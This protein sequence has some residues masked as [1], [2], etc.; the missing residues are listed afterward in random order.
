MSQ[1]QELEQY[2]D[3]LLSAALAQCGNL[4]DAEDLA[5]D[6]VLAVLTYL[7]RGGTIENMRAFLTTVIRRTFYGRLREKYRFPTVSLDDHPEVYEIAEEES[8]DEDYQRMM[9]E[10]V[11]LTESYREVL[12]RHYFRGQGL[13]KIADAL[14]IP[15]GTVKSRL[16]MGREKIRKGMDTNMEEYQEQSYAP[17]RLY[18]WNSGNPGFNGEP[19][20][21][22]NDDLIA[23]NLLILAYPAPIT[24]SDLAKA[25][26]IATA[27]V[28]PIVNKL[29]DNELMKRVSNRVYTDFLINDPAKIPDTHDKQLAFVKKNLELIFTP[30]TA[31]LNAIKETD[32]FRALPIDEQQKFMLFIVMWCLDSGLF[33]AEERVVGEQVFPER[34]NG[35]HWIAVGNI[36]RERNIPKGWVDNT[37]CG[38]YHHLTREFHD[39]KEICQH[40]YGTRFGYRNSVFPSQGEINKLLYAIR[41]GVDLRSAGLTEQLVHTDELVKWGFLRR[42]GDTLKTAIPFVEMHDFHDMIRKINPAIEQISC[43]LEEPMR[44][45]LADKRKKSPPHLTSVPAPKLVYGTDELVVLSVQEAMDRGVLPRLDY[46]CTAHI[47]VYWKG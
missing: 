37:Y 31:S 36:Q 11:Y 29:V 10:L 33:V 7:D 15:V 4:T 16:A 14:G 3:F 30:I 43:S 19:R 20:S 34:P 13:E 17:E 47:M 44:A 22:V 21:L 18:V 5:S 2:L 26:G 24:V 38:K 1:I 9:K 40:G 8:R 27:Y 12:V 32:Y 35:G 25:I 39:T 41:E 45:Y 46:P 6:T 28:E 23:Q 42:N